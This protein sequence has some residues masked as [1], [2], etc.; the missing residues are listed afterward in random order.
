[1]TWSLMV[2][3]LV[4][5]MFVATVPA[6]AQPAAQVEPEPPEERAGVDFE[7][8]AASQDLHEQ[9]QMF[10]EMGMGEKEALFFSLMTSGKMDP[11]TM[12]MLMA[13]MG[14]GMGGDEMGIMLLMN[15]MSGNKAAAQPV[16]LDRGETLLIIDG[17][18][19]YKVNLETMA[20]AGSVPY[21][22]AAGADADALTSL[23]RM[24][25]THRVERERGAVEVAEVA[26][27][28]DQDE[29][30]GNLRGLCLAALTRAED[31][32]GKLPGET[33]VADIRGYHENGQVL[34]CPSRPDLA[35]GYAM[36]RKLLG[37]KLG[38][39]EEP[40]EVILFFEANLDG[41]N[42]VGGADDVP[43]EGV[44]NGG[45][46]L[47]FADGHCKWVSV[48]EARELLEQELF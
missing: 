48:E 2:A 12:M 36:N 39:V 34:V 20:L 18:V 33:W 8:M 23:L 32:E 13:M 5:V 42:P 46:N 6:V 14:G 21:A 28:E 1:M 44:H 35:V 10:I 29:C 47:G 3:V 24:M 43:E 45:I 31:F 38:E 16:V 4:G 19:L 22:R 9:M 17:G 25:M 37:A 26:V 15:A 7:R 40:A 27:D 30:I 41:E 11:A